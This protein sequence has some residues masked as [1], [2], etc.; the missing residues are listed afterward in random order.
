M[1]ILFGGAGLFAVVMTV[2][3][4]KTRRAFRLEIDKVDA[5]LRAKKEANQ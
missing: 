5:L 4:L 3:M 1:I 2:V